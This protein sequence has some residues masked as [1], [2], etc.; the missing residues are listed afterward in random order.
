MK[1][2][3]TIS[4]LCLS[5]LT[6]QTIE[7]TVAQESDLGIKT[8]EVTTIKS[9]I[10]SPYN[11]TVIL[12]KKDVI[13]LGANIES[14]V[15]DIYVSDLE[16]VN[17]GQKLLTLK[18]NAL[19]S[20]QKEYIESTIESASASL[21][22]ERNLKLESGGIISTKKL[23]ESKQRKSSAEVIVKL[24]ANQ[25]LT[26]G[27]STAML[28]KIKETHVPIV[29]KNIYA[30]TS[31]VIY[32]VDV[33]VG[34]Y[35]Q[36]DHMLLGIYGDGKRFIEL[37]VPVKVA[38]NLT[39]GDR[40]SF[41][42][43]SATVMA[44]GNVVNASSQSVEI[45]AEIENA[46]GIFINRIYEVKIH[47]EVSNAVKIKKTALV[48]DDGESY[49][50]KKVSNGFDVVSVKIISEG[51]VCYIVQSDLKEGDVLAATS[52]SALLSVMESNDE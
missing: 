8:Q 31:G 1:K 24:N 14:I 45:R 19:L 6:A 34:E 16:H 37:S 33:N 7:V 13:T 15:K 38:E 27:F 43:Y 28:R 35:I 25:L 9:I 48:F 4:L 5:V 29:E 3:I 47:K 36:A 2:I 39:L 12:D 21:N 10:H 18:S 32:K 30:P 52:T 41:S 44:I 22:Y 17:R 51:P 46:E 26:N 23:L 11:G 20:L 50:F 40:C 42:K 49:V